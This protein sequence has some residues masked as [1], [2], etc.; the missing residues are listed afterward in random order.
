M[1]TSKAVWRSALGTLVALIGLSAPP[2]VGA[3]FLGGSPKT[4]F[5]FS[6]ICLDC[7]GTVTGKLT[8]QNYVPGTE[9]DIPN[10]VSFVYDGSDLLAPFSVSAND[11]EFFDGALNADGTLATS[12]INFGSFQTSASNSDD[13]F[14]RN[15][16]FW[17]IGSSDFGNSGQFTP[18]LVPAPATL[19][20]L[21]LGLAGLQ[22]RR[23]RT[24]ALA[25]T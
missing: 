21:S 8:L 3:A 6:G 11:L 16:G 1:P 12:V 9:I 19:A 24:A 20:L 4:V 17:V 18:A 22:L 7:I 2:I 23:R 15:N 13:F 14:I 10:F 25:R 5:E